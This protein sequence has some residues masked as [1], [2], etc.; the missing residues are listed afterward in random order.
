MQKKEENSAPLQLQL[1][2][3]YN[4]T[5]FFFASWVYLW[6]SILV[7]VSE[8]VKIKNSKKETFIFYFG[9]FFKNFFN[10]LDTPAKWRD[11]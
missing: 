1:D 7:W 6:F 10:V 9:T 5:P 11:V 3:I 8:P 2:L 4:Y